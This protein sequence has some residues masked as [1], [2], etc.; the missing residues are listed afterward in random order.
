MIKYKEMSSISYSFIAACDLDGGIG[1]NG[2]MAWHIKEDMKRFRNITRSPDK[3]N[4]VIMGRRTWESLNETPLPDRINI[5]VSKTLS[6]PTETYIYDKNAYFVSSLENALKVAA[7][8]KSNIFVIGGARLYQEALSDHRCVNGYLT[9]VNNIF[10]CDTF[11]HIDMMDNYETIIDGKWQT[12]DVTGLDF[13]Y[14]DVVRI[15]S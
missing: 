8:E 2:Q 1:K 7:S 11:F 13:R 3:T 12:D 14:I 4:V 10:D 9:I 15:L 5:V 6:S